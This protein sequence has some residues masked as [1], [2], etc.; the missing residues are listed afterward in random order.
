MRVSCAAHSRTWATEPGAEGELVGVDGL[1]RV[2][3][4]EG[5]RLGLHRGG[6]LLELDLGQHAH[7]VPGRPRR[8]ARSATWA[9]LSSPVT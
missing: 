2:D 6:D 8:R 9:P 5:R 4:A 1:D 7:R 3:D